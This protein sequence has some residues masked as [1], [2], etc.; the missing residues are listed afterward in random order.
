VNVEQVAYQV[1]VQQTFW[2]RKLH[3][4]AGIR[5]NDFNSPLLILALQA[6]QSLNHYKPRF[7]FQI[8][9]CI[10]WVLSFFS[11]NRAG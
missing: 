6:K 9:I 11:V 2:N 7:G 8:S 5:K 3:I 1:R 4:E 10:G